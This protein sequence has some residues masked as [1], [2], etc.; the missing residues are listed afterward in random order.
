[1]KQLCV[2][3]VLC[4]MP[5]LLCA[6]DR[7]ACDKMASQVSADWNLQSTLMGQANAFWAY[8]KQEAV[9]LM[10]ESI[11][12]GQRALERCN[13]TLQ[14]IAGLSKGDRRLPYWKHKQEEMERNRVVLSEGLRGLQRS[15]NA[16]LGEIVFQKALPFYQKSEERAKEALAKSEM[17]PQLLGNLRELIATL[18][19]VRRLYEE[20]ASF[21][22]EALEAMAAHPE[23]AYRSALK[24]AILAYK[25]AAG[26]YEKEAAGWQALILGQVQ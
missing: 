15:L 17:C 19:E 1:M 25:E 2:F 23:E 21:A 10:R 22:Q 9:R 8:D 7:K 14:K 6:F 11:A 20:A 5:G 13:E 4:A 26:V 18:T 16:M 24:Q 12:C 3:L